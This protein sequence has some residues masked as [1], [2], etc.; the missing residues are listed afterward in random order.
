MFI[1]VEFTHH[2][3]V[4]EMVKQRDKHIFYMSVAYASVGVAAYSASDDVPHDL[5]DVLPDID[6]L[7]AL[8]EREDKESGVWAVW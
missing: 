7:K 3:T 4:L 5:R 8:L 6:D 2:C 1:S